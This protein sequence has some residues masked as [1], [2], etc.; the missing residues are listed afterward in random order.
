MGPELAFLVASGNR[1]VRVIPEVVLVASGN[2]MVPVIPG[3]GG[4]AGETGFRPWSHLTGYRDCTLSIDV[5]V[6]SQLTWI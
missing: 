5:K 4:P 1:M 2:R 6:Q 3:G